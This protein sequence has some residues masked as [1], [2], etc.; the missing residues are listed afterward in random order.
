MNK[1]IGITGQ[2]GAGKSEVAKY[3]AQQGA[4][5]LSVRAFLEE[6]IA[7]GEEYDREKLVNIAN[8]MRKENGPD[9]IIATLCK[10][11]KEAPNKIAVIESIRSKGEVNYLKDNNHTLL[12]VSAHPRVRYERIIKRAASTDNI[13]FEQFV[14]D[15]SRESY[16]EDNNK[17][18]ITT[19]MLNADIKIRNDG[20][21]QLLK[22]RVFDYVLKN[23]STDHERPSWDN[24]FLQMLPSISKRA[25]CDRG[26]AG[27]I[28][29]KD[30]R[31]LVTG[32]V[33]APSGLPH[34]DQIGHQMKKVVHED[35]S[36]SNHCVRTVH[37]EQNAICQAAKH[38]ISIEG[39]TMYAKMVPC[40][41]CAMLIINCGIKRIVCEKQYHAGAND[42]LQLAGVELI[43]LNDDIEK[44]NNQ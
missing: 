44:Y 26:R 5:H 24:Y 43:V 22:K 23:M 27:C 42:M 40:R 28:I 30:N 16:S 19:C 7:E 31:L 13:T 3:L 39:G 37:A 29:T 4:L 25:T 14:E 10:R 11:A 20:D 36:E 6:H 34:C 35:G 18:S 17:Q 12:S 15:E 21:L 32:Y 8:K 1:I 33:G 2:Q 38:G 9:Y 41:V